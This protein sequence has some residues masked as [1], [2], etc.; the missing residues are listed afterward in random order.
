M[1]SL[2]VLCL[3]LP[4]EQELYAVFALRMGEFTLFQQKILAPAKFWYPVSKPQ[5]SHLS[6][7]STLSKTL[8]VHY[9]ICID[10]NQAFS[11]VC[12]FMW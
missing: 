2:A 5:F 7:G 3:L 10:F 8:A 11:I 12:C 6:Y 9:S 1:L 4:G